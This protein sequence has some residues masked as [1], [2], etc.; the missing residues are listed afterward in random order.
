MKLLSKIISALLIGVSLS[1]YYW[2]GSFVL[3]QSPSVMRNLE[4]DSSN[5]KVYVP[6]GIAIGAVVFWIIKK[7]IKSFLVI[8]II[9][10]II[11]ILLWW[12][13]SSSEIQQYIMP[14]AIL[15]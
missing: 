5:L 6:V 8:S 15:K 12:L 13:V 2:I 11:S 4:L 3:S 1:F 10:F 7:S 14:P 9:L